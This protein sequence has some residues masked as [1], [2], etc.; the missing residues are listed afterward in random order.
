[1]MSPAE[2]L[3]YNSNDD[4]SDSDNI[5]IIL[6]MM[7]TIQTGGSMNHCRNPLHNLVVLNRLIFS[8][9]QFNKSLNL[10]YVRVF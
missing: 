4:N 5:M 6:I 7:I 10:S 9:Y 2:I 3:F 8:K 1:M